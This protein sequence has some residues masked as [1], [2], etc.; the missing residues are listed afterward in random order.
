MKHHLFLF[1]KFCVLILFCG[2]FT[3]CIKNDHY[4]K[5]DMKIKFYNLVDGPSQD[6]YLD[7]TRLFVGLVYGSNTDYIIG[8]GDLPYS[9]LAKNS[10]TKIISDSL[11]QTLAVGRNYSVFY[12]KNVAKD[13]VLLVYNDD[14][15]SD[16]TQSKLL[17]LNLG[18]TLG[19][20]VVIRDSVGLV[21][22]NLA[23]GQKSNYIYVKF[24]G[25]N[26]LYLNLADSLNVVDTLKAINFNKG[27][28]YTILFDG[29]RTG[30]LQK[31]LIVNN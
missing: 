10:G 4:V 22:E 21:H 26:K 25:K 14:L 15:T 28:V 19:S 29:S 17:F 23:Y 7:A 18:Y 2:L 11:N 5:G 31:R 20:D 30:K 9:I 6:F 1:S 16:T 3:S 13:S 8:E 27:K 24:N 12:T